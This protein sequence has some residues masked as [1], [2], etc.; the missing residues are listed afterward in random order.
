[1]INSIPL[2]ALVGPTAGGKTTVARALAEQKLVTLIPV[3]TTRP[4][5]P[6]EG[7]DPGERRFVSED[8][9]RR[10]SGEGAFGL[11]GGYPG[12]PYRFGL[13]PL[14]EP[15]GIA[16]AVLRVDEVSALAARAGGVR[17]VYQ[18]CAPI[19]EVAERLR[20]RG[21]SEYERQR[22]LSTFH[23]ERVA[24]TWVSDRT[25]VNRGPITHLV[26]AVS[27]ALA[28][29]LGCVAPASAQRSSQLLLASH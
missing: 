28:A 7:R 17:L 16:L 1:M 12:T 14:D 13:S 15:R 25:F 19:D 18:V 3:W 10:L 27:R 21:V 11:T 22:C 8:A 20:R 9:F 5:R 2:L 6:G 23:A 4:A 29:D 24:G 26:T